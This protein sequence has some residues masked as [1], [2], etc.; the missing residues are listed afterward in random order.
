VVHVNGFDH[1]RSLRRF[2]S[3]RLI[4]QDHGGFDPRQVRVLRRWWMRSGLRA[5]RACLVAT[6][7]QIDLFR[8]TGIV[9]PQVRLYDVLEGST[10]LRAAARRQSRG[11]PALLW[12]GRLNDN[13]D[14][15]T[16]LDGFARFAAQQPGATLTYVYQDGDLEPQLRAAI[17]GNHRLCEA[18]VLR[19]AVAHAR[20]ADEYAAADF[21]VLGSH[22]ES[23]GYAVLEALACGAV[24]VVTD[25]PSYRW[26]TDSGSIGALWTPGDARSLCAALQR[27]IA[28]PIE[29]QRAACRRRFD[30]HLS[31]DAIGRR[32]LAIY[33]EVSRS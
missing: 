8:T 7:P 29:S 25:I 32:A 31:W 22:H 21:F 9:P 33:E 12:V 18:V 26:M 27:A 17:Q 2:R 3:A 28:Q 4:V 11:R 16:V 23:T 20:L 19:G 13:K 24:P 14:P 1:P 6:P 5:A 30:A 15:L 10:T